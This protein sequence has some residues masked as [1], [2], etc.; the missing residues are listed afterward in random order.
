MSANKKKSGPLNGFRIIELAGIGPGPYCGQLFADLGADVIVIER[1]GPT[2]STVNGRG[3][4]S[5]I[6]DLRK[7]GAADIVL[8]L[9]QGADALIEGNRPGVA[10]R[11]GVGPKNC[12]ARNAKLV[13]GRMTGWGQ[14]GPW[15]QSA[16]HDI[17]YISITGALHAFG[18]SDDVPTPPLNLVGDYG[19]GAL[20]L[21]FGVVA[22]LL[23]AQKTG[24]G[25]VVDAA[26]IDGASSMMGII[27]SLMALN[28]WTP[29][30]E[31]NLLDGGA[32]FYRCYK[33]ADGKFMAV[34]C[35]E[36][37]FF[38]LMLK[39]LEIPAEQYGDQ[40]DKSVWPAQ[41]EKLARVFAAK[42]R[43]HW[44]SRF[45]GTDACVTPVLDLLE[46]QEHPHV[47]ARDIYTQSGGVTHPQAAPRFENSAP[48][49]AFSLPDKG[50]DTRAVLAGA[51]Y[52]QAQIEAMIEDALIYT[53]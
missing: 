24:K 36:P 30:R 40:H 5:I 13:Y 52:S 45:D 18:K 10:E 19:G 27:Y 8:E 41:H 39:I 26:I 42:S 15:A 6:V 22:A 11:L 29:A 53:D 7:P 43:E 25:D 33:T 1:P 20:F 48:T 34:G 16:G 51:G 23:Q 47:K 28:L 4:K 32:P 35:I 31:S 12:Q 50:A 49:H 21:A 2:M 3:K 38:T 14:D 9:A 46:A 17:N 37:Q 44:S